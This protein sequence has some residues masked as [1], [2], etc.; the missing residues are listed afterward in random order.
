MPHGR[1]HFVV[2]VVAHSVSAV[3]LT[4]HT[5]GLS[6]LIATPEDKLHEPYIRVMLIWG[7]HIE[8]FTIS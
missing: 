4:R 2:V 6:S 8:R 3:V 1:N 7:G 5:A